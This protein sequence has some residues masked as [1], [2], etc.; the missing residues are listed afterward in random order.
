MDKIRIVGGRPL[1]GEVH[2]SGAKNAALPALFAC[3][4]TDMPC[5]LHK[6]PQLRDIESARQVLQKMGAECRVQDDKTTV[7]ARTL[8]TQEAPYALVKTMRASILALGPLL[9]RCGRARVSLPGGCAIGARPVDMHLDGLRKMGATIDIEDG[10]IVA[11]AGR[12]RGAH[13]VLPAPTV[14][15]SENLMMAAALAAGES[16]IEN[17]A[18]EPEIADL[19]SFLNNMGAKISGAGSGTLHICGVEKLTGAAHTVLPDRIEAGTYLCAVAAC[20]G[21]VTVH[22]AGASVMQDL[23]EKLSTAGAVLTV[24]GESV[25]IAVNG[26]MR[27]V[28]ADTAPYPGFP[29]DMQAQWMA[30]SSVAEGTAVISENVFENRFMHVPELSRLGANIE[31]RNNTA[32][33]QGV[34]KLAGAPMMA[35]DLRASASLVIAALAAAG[36]SVIERIYHLERGYENLTEKLQA[37]GAEV[38]RVV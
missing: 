12:L 24:T 32:V 17:A 21:E 22:N 1:I 33:V 4:L 30:V 19:A 23:L 31:L 5:T 7:C 18:R 34:E 8:H 36:T 27:A 9:A 13:I 3:L 25:R 2:I 35:T 37:L 16:I 28:N 14:T 20:G 11:S 10:N 6:L 38:R 15:G 26:R 29:T